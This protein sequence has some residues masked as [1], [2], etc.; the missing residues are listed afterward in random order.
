[1]PEHST[2]P[3]ID[4]YHGISILPHTVKQY[5]LITAAAILIDSLDQPVFKAVFGDHLTH[6]AL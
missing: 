5:M 1:M 4:N 2:F 6:P 3:H